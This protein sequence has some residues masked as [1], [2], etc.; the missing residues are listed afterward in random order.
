[1]HLQINSINIKANMNIKAENNDSWL[2]SQS[3]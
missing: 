1:M 2:I 3:I